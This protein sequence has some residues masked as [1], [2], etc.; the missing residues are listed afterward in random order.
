M[1]KLKAKTI[2]E[3]DKYSDEFKKISEKIVK[4]YG[5]DFNEYKSHALL[6]NFLEGKGFNVKR[7]YLR[8]Q[9]AF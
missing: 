3:I 8:I 4:K 7:S 2:T 9:T 5:L 6:T 1:A